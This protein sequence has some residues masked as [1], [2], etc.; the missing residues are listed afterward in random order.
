MQQSPLL[1]TITLALAV[2]IC[3][4][5]PMI[6]HILLSLEPGKDHQPHVD[7]SC[8]TAAPRAYRFGNAGTSGHIS[9]TENFCDMLQPGR[10]H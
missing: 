6:R 10:R 5:T 4:A 3:K 8:S 7:V 2:H 9:D 1:G